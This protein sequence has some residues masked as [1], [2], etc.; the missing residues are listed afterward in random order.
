MKSEKSNHIDMDKA[1]L[2]KLSKSELI[3]LLLKQEKKKPKIIVLDDTKQVP[4]PRTYKPRP[5]V[6]TPRKSV[7][8][9]AKE[10][11]ENII[12]PPPEFRDNYKPVPA[13]RTKQNAVKKPVP[14]PRTKIEQTDKA[15]KGYTK[16]YE[17]SIKNNKDPLPQMQ[18][19]RKAIEHRVITLLNEMKGLKY[20]ETLKVTFSKMSDGETVIKTAYFNSTVQTIIN[21]TEINEALQMSKQNILNLISQWISEGSGWT[22]QS[23]DSPYLNIVKYK[24][25]KGSS[26]IQLPH[27]LRN[28]AKGL[29]NM[30]NEDNECF[31]WCHI[32]H[33]NP[34]EKYPQRIKK[35]DKQ[36]VGKLDYSNI[37]FP[38]S[39]K[40]YNK[41]EKQNSINI[42]VFG[43]EDKQTYP[44]YVSKEKYEDH[45]ELL[46]ITE[47]ENK[48]YV[49]I[50]DIT[51]T[52]HITKQNTK[53]ENT[54]VCTVFNVS[55]L[56]EY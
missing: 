20:V 36:Y 16:S 56:K 6:P 50:K 46:L 18:N 35:T 17:I 47:N 28:S 27:E 43:Y 23:V 34:Q 31:R 9:M 19:T 26:Y 13:P 52:K 15:L 3:K 33:L 29:I 42:S 21:H 54:F 49:L 5:P 7:E 40:H 2:K 39:V 8:Q 55:V 22:I 14:T 45:M 11:E 4:A 10:Y 1:S 24:P 44:I 30:K 37:E 48:H 32:R 51:K 12:L 25:M 41:I 53:R 38:V